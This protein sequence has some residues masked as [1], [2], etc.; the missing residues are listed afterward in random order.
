MMSPTHHHARLR[1]LGRAVTAFAVLLAA[2]FLTAMPA[3]GE[4]ATQALPTPRQFVSHLDL[5]C[6]RTDPY[7]PPAVNILTRHINPVLADLPPEVVTLGP[8]EQLCVPVAKNGIL[9]PPDVL[10]F[11]RAV[12]LSCYRIQGQSVD[13]QLKLRHLNPQLWDVP[14][15]EI[16]ITYPE[17]LCV[18][19][20]KNGI[21]PP[22]HI[23]YL[24][25][26]IDV[27]CYV[28]KPQVPLD[29]NLN[30][31]H[32]NPVFA[33]FPRHD[34]YVSYNRQLCVPVWKNDE[35]IPPEVFEIIRW[36]DLEKYDIQTPPL[37][38]PYNL[39]INHINPSLQWLPKEPVTMYY[40]NQL[41]LPVAKNGNLPPG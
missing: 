35:P 17:Q 9:P 31:S 15:K 25:R 19:V 4:P 20:V 30:L 32:L 18:P 33:N 26:H 21:Y 39:W 3:S 5:E 37:P 1:A 12:D 16:W 34:A 14:E 41:M 22:D 36:I 10:D 8:R 6:F 11:I 23:L 38:Q 2:G 13:R 27:K 28:E 7:Q 29:K 24:I 40:G